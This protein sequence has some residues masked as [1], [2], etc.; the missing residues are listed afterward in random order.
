M[1]PR[2]LLLL[3]TSLTLATATTVPRGVSPEGTPSDSSPFR[4]LSRINH[5]ETTDAKLYTPS[6]SQTFTCLT[7]PSIEISYDRV[8]DDFCDCPDGSD[9]PGTSA[10][11]NLAH[12]DIAIP[13]FYCHNKGHT[14]AYLPNSRVNDGICDYD[15]CCDGLDEAGG[16]GGVSC[17]SKCKEIGNAARKMAAERSARRSKA[18][19]ARRELVRKAKVLKKE[20]EDNVA[21]TKVKVQANEV[22]IRELE[23]KL[24]ETEERE[25]NRVAKN[26]KPGSRVSVVTQVA[27][28]KVE[29]LQKL[30]A[31][32][33]GER[34]LAE[35]R[36]EKAEAMLR[37]L[38]EEYNPNFNDEG[39]KH[40]VRSWEEYLAGGEQKR[41]PAEDRDFNAVL[42]EE[43]NWDEL[44][45][46][47]EEEVSERMTS[48]FADFLKLTW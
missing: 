20:V 14:P 3:A 7:H 31:K 18:A 16:V 36:L 12:K 23:K 21:T 11:A 27:K 17:P 46:P 26:P 47:E 13:G 30:L 5:R 4:P 48:S 42:N 6:N 41:N 10:C 33:R 35:E 28:E 45:G 2:K 19:K 24:Q 8:N 15:I 43:T 40:A 9:E 37:L 44:A 29:E 39:V 25:R 32:V 38:K 22:K 1:L 34:D